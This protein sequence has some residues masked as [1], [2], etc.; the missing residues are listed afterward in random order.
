MSISHAFQLDPYYPC[1][2]V[3][4]LTG[5]FSVND[6][7]IKLELTLRGDTHQVHWPIYPRQ[8]TTGLWEDTCFEFFLGQVGQ[9]HYVEVNLSPGG[10]W[11]SF[12][13]RDVR[14]DMVETKLIQLSS[15]QCQRTDTEAHFSAT[16]THE[17]PV[18]E[19]ELGISA[20]VKSEAGK[21]SYYALQ[22]SGSRPD[23]HDR[24]GWCIQLP[25]SKQT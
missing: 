22:H 18:G 25:I 5:V 20:V 4:D 17:L 7:N 15:S 3:T 11:N 14:T 19:Y 9:S 16:L 6:S 24:R 10:A 2:P 1:D 8:R 23:F 13:F 12:A 21:L